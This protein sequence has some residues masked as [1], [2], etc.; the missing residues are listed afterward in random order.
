MSM[1]SRKGK[2]MI[3]KTLAVAAIAVPAL[4]G[5]A[6]AAT[7][8]GA[9]VKVDR[10]SRLVAVAGARGQV[11][12]VHTSK[13]AVR[14]LKTGSRVTFAA[15]TLRNGTLASSRFRVVGRARTV[16]VRGLVL[17]SNSR[18]FAM[19]AGGAVLSVKSARAPRVGSTV[20]ASVAPRATG[21]AS[22]GVTVVD[23]SASSGSIEGHVVSATG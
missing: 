22:T 3:R 20:V 13:V 7:K 16:R 18:S 15:R 12:L 10:P 17:R 8:Q 2:S 9:V 11:A 1:N 19:S 4:P 6:H 5:V 14:N 23:P 21:L